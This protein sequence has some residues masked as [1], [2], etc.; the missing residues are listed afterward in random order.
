[1]SIAHRIRLWNKLRKLPREKPQLYLFAEHKFGY[2][3]IPKVASRAIRSAVTAFMSDVAPD[4][5][6]DKSLEEEFEARYA[7]HMK[8]R[9]I[10]VLARDNF[11]FA[12]VRNPYERIHSCYKN[13]IEDVR[14]FGG[15]NIF[16]KHGIG[17]GV[18]F[19]EFVRRVSSLPDNKSDRHFRSQAWFLTLEGLLFPSFVGKLENLSEDWDI[20]EKRFGIAPPPKINVSSVKPLPEM[21]VQTKSLICE[22]YAEDFKLF[23]Y[24]Q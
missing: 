22:R 17:L 8:H 3:Q 7:Q 5:A 18:T 9:E 19:D 13:K 14:N 2:V 10:A 23:G 16:E 11:I 1:M 20:L 4:E 15:S 12:F 21:S 24:G 6:V